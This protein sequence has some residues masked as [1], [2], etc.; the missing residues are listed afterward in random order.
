MDYHTVYLYAYRYH[1]SGNYISTYIEGSQNISFLSCKKTGQLI[2][3][4]DQR[5]R[6]RPFH[7]KLL[8]GH[9][10]TS[11]YI[12]TKQ[13]NTADEST[14]HTQQKKTTNMRTPYFFLTLSQ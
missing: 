6:E 10:V 11:T 7:T 8:L 9:K 5:T 13:E 1:S 4:N 14:L 2:F 3:M 12:I